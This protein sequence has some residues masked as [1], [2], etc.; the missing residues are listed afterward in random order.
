MTEEGGGKAQGRKGI[1]VYLCGCR[2]LISRKVDLEAIAQEL[3]K[4]E[5]VV[6]VGIHEALC[7]KE[8]Q[9]FLK[10]EY[11]SKGFERASVAAC[12]PNIQGLIV[13]RSLEEEGMNKY[14]FEQVNIRE[15]CAWVHPDRKAA[16]EKARSL[17][18]GAV[19]RTELLEPLEDIEV[20]ID[21]A[22][23]VIGGG[24]AGM[25]AALDIAAQG[26]KVH[27]VERSEELGGRA[28]KLSMTFPTHNCG[29]CC[30]QYCKECVFTPKI[31]DVVQ[32]KN[33]E[34]LLRSEVQGIEGGF[35][36]RH[37]TVKTP[38]GVREFDVGTVIVAT[39][40]KTFDP[41]RIPELR[42]GHPNVIT[43]QE[44]EQII[45]EQREKGGGLRRRS[46]GKVP[47]TVN[48]IQ[49]V[50]SR[51]KMKGNLHCSL[52]CCTYAIGQAREIKKLDP[53]TNVY[54]HYI[55][56]RGPYRGFEEFY[57]AAKEEGIQFV[58]GRV[59]EVVQDRDKIFVRAADTDSDTLLNIESDLVVLAVG[60]E[61]AEGSDAIVKLLHLQTDVDRFIKDINPM[62]PSEF[63]RGI[64]I[65]GTAQGPKGI[66]YSIEDAKSA[67]AA[68]AE[69]MKKG[70]VKFPR[71][72]AY[73]DETRCRGC[74]RCEETC[75]Y[76]AVTVTKDPKTGILVSKVDEIRCEGCGAC[77]VACCNKAI[78]VNNFKREQVEAQIRAIIEEAMTDG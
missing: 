45:V 63:R 46:D 39:G 7:S 26:F 35:G 70:T 65:A 27:L 42:Y 50:G 44:L 51:D 19:A 53:E 24:V 30:M 76:G 54:I 59:S 4:D 64:Y 40:S 37:V 23:L 69:L 10:K 14:L 6:A 32:N 17:I 72:V 71:I 56:L 74:G 22:A 5:R 68:A 67:A 77:A 29:I 57:S 12:S 55:D 18:E 48:F 3:R 16:T 60:Q 34:V 66:R 33:I 49:C 8:G 31:E 1:A 61:P 38:G 41:R 47:R 9:E 21:P 15:Q 75:E 62:F 13:S 36:K 43:T 25:Q 2:D 11:A 20:Q 73:V 58:R 78:T 28:Y 52:V